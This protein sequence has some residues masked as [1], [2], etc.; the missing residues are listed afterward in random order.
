V[1]LRKQFDRQTLA[2]H[3]RSVKAVGRKSILPMRTRSGKNCSPD[4]ISFWT[5]SFV[6]TNLVVRQLLS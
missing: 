4:E 3:S 1:M 2:P 5:H 6:Q